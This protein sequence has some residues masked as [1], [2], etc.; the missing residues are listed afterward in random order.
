MRSRLVGKWPRSG[1]YHVLIT[2]T[3]GQTKT[4]DGSVRFR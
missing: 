4:Y 2:F 1:G 3:T